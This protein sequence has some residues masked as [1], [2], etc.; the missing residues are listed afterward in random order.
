M[1]NFIS[2]DKVKKKLFGVLTI[3]LIGLIITITG[4][5]PLVCFVSA[6]EVNKVV[7][8]FNDCYDWVKTLH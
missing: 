4:L 6:D 8:G 7:W 1:I 3:I 2:T 5:P